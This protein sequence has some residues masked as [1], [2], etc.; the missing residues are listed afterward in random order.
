MYIALRPEQRRKRLRRLSRRAR[1]N[2]LFVAGCAL[3]PV[4]SPGWPLPGQCPPAPPTSRFRGLSVLIVCSQ[5]GRSLRHFLLGGTVAPS[6][7]EHSVSRW[8]SLFR[9][10]DC[11]SLMRRAY[12]VSRFVCGLRTFTPN[13]SNVPWRMVD[14][15]P[16]R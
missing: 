11:V 5:T 13:T 15:A 10:E 6:T 7:P 2:V 1:W 3:A 14:D 8:Y 9:V 4:G 16:A 12:S